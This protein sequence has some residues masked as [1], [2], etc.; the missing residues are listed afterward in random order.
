[1]NRDGKYFDG[2]TPVSKGVACFIV[3][4]ELHIFNSETEE[5]IDQ[6]KKEDIFHDEVHNTVMVIG[7]KGSKARIELY[8]LE[9]AKNLGLNDKHIIKKDIKHIFGWI[10]ILAVCS[11]LF[12]LSIPMMTKMIAKRIPYDVERK[13]AAK[14]P[15]EQQFT[16]C[17]LD[18]EEKK[19]LDEYAHFLYP[20]SKSEESMPIDFMV[21]DNPMINAFTFP[22][23]RIVLMKGIIKE[24]K[25]PQELLGIMSHE[26]GHVI[27]RDSVSFVVRGTFL[28][29][30]FGFL[31]G[32]FSSSF[33]VSPQIFLSTAALTF[34]RDME[35]MADGFA[36]ERL[37]K[38]DVSTSGLRS[39]FSRR[40]SE[41]SL[42]GP[43]LFMT[44]P[45][46]KNRI[47]SIIETYPKVDLP[48][49]LLHNWKII[50]DICK[51]KAP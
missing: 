12:W 47:N 28:A 1:M 4:G 39:F 41:N 51:T 50:K 46:Y 31:T 11:C 5:K 30:F 15:I 8:N 43:E 37:K 2:K 13:Y 7:T 45:D 10:G 40:E 19:A 23:G 38:M 29:S 27:A 34:D 3:G 14:I 42:S 18:E 24:A 35:K 25:T 21:A 9:I 16:L 36:V 44:H 17:K 48:E 22:G 49:S 33:A 6:W 26:I 20:K 32:D